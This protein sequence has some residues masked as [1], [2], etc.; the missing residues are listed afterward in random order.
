MLVPQIS[1][2]QPPRAG[3]SSITIPEDT[4]VAHV[5]SADSSADAA[6]PADFS[7]DLLLMA[8]TVYIPTAVGRV[9]Q[10][11]PVLDVVRPATMSG[12]VAIA[13][14]AMDRQPERRFR[15]VL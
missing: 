10:L 7:W 8:V 13:C 12:L 15:D 6:L 9:H 11:F 1:N 3:A 5:V 4:F 2:L 14:Y